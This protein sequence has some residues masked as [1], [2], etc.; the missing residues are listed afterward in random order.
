LTTTSPISPLSK[1]EFES[2]FREYFKPLTAFAFKF[3][4]DLDDAKS[5]VHDVFARVWEKRAEIDLSKSVRSYLYTSVNNRSLNYVR[6]RKKF[7]KHASDDELTNTEHHAEWN[8]LLSEDD[9][10]KR[11]EAALEAMGTKAKEVFLL[12]RNEGLKYN[13]IAEKLNLS[14]KTVETHM[15]TALK[16]LRNY[17]K[18]YLTGILILILYNQL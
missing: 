11:V 6:D 15:S 3:T 9:I 13:E 18:E 10:H 7:V 17:L 1:K 4:K 2:L 12:S 5:I 8:D 16:E 14:V